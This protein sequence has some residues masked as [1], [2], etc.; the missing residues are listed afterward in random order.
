MNLFEKNW[1]VYFHRK[2]NTELFYI[3][4]GKVKKYQKRYKSPHGRNPHWKRI[5]NKYN[6]FTYEKVAENL[7]MKEACELEIFLI[8]EYGLSSLANITPGGEGVSIKVS[9]EG[10]LRMSEAHKGVP[11]QKHHA[12]AIRKSRKYGGEHWMAKTVID[13]QTGKIYGSI[14]LAAEAIG[15]KYT[16]LY[17][18]VKGVNKNNTSITFLN[19]EI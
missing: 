6:G 11:L 7:S 14:K 10:K 16:T 2:H 18:K 12:D 9:E 1:Y 8:E 15:M 4:I 5:V 3:G 17:N 19:Q 13:N